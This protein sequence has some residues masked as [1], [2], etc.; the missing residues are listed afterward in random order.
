MS[1]RNNLALQEQWVAHDTSWP[2][3]QS[4]FVFL[5]IINGKGRFISKQQHHVLSA[6]DLIVTRDLEGAR[7]LALSRDGLLL[8]YFRT[9]LEYLLPLF[10]SMDMCRTESLRIGLPL[11]TFLPASAPLAKECQRIVGQVAPT[12]S[13]EHR[14]QLLNVVAKMFATHLQ[15]NPIQHVGQDKVQAHLLGILENMGAEELQSLS[16]KDLA[17]RFGCSRRHLNRLFQEHFGT[18]VSALKMEMRLLKAAALLRHPA[19]K[20]ANVALESGFSHLGLFSSCFKRRFGVRPSEWRRKEQDPSQKHSSSESTGLHIN[21][22]NG[23]FGE[24]SC[25]L[26]HMGLCPWENGHPKFLIPSL[27]PPSNRPQTDPDP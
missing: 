17:R 7:L 4:G 8:K 1:A 20:I 16:V 3:E 26:A 2:F 10:D 18:S 25:R 23:A 12:P 24:N 15:S 19:A 27:S 11:V 13:L 9:W 22:K 6:G 21:P 5:F 14:C